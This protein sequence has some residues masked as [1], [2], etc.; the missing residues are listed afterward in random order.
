MFRRA[1]L[2]KREKIC[3]MNVITPLK[4]YNVK[5]SEEEMKNILNGVKDL[6]NKT[7]DIN[8]VMTFDYDGKKVIIMPETILNSVIE[9]KVY[10]KHWWGRKKL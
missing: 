3:Y 10:E 2:H 9:Y 1:Q 6:T 8:Y 5:I 4:E 7:K